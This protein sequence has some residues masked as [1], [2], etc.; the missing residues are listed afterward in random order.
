[1]KRYTCPMHSQ[2]IKDE[3]GNC[4]LCGM[5]LVAMGGT[6]QSHAHHHTNNGHN[7][8]EG[9]HTSEFLQRFWVSMVLTIPILL[10]SE[11]IQQ[12]FGFKISFA[13]DKYVL[14]ALGTFLYVYGGS[15]FLKGMIGEI[16]A[17]AIGMMT[18]VAL[19]ISVAYL[20]SAAV[21]FGLAGMDFFW[22][23]ATLIDIM[24]LG[25][26]LEMR[27]QTA[28]SKALQS[29]VALLPSTVRIEKGDE[30]VEV[31]LDHLHSD[32]IFIIRPGEKIPADGAVVAG[33]SY[34]NESFLTGESVPIKKEDGNKVIAGSI[35][36]DGMLKVRATG[37]G[38]DSYLNKVIN[39]VQEAQ[40]TKSKTQNLADTV[41]KWLTYIAILAGSM[42]FLYWY[43]SGVSLSYALE[44]MVT[45]MV[46]ACPHALGVAIPLVV[47]IS[48]TLSATNGLLIRNRTAFEIARNIDIIV[49]DKTG[50]LTKGSHVIHHIIPLNTAYDEQ[51]IIQYAAAAQQHSEHHIAKGILNYL[52]EKKWELWSSS[53]FEY[54]Q[55]MGVKSQVNDKLIVAAGPNYFKTNNIDIPDIPIQI[56][57]SVE[58]VN[59]L[60]ID[61]TPVGIITFADTIREGAKETIDS[62]KDMGIQ[63]HLLTGDNEHIAKY[64]CE[65]LNMD[66]YMSSILPHQKQEKIKDFQAQGSIVAMTGDGVNDAPALAQANVGIAVG[67][68]TD[69]AAETADIILVHSDPRDVVKII[70]F[71]KRSYKKM[72]QN[73]AWAVGYNIIAIPLAAGVLAPHFILSPAIGAILMSLSTII[74]AFNASLLKINKK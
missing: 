45:V 28:A 20:Y 3:P 12:W 13:G 37:V 58:T 22:E 10:L 66:G 50:T 72:I 61:G 47:S 42:T 63:T 24:L 4:P 67:S 32:D 55:G 6:T 15:P 59:F 60:L 41:A 68:G 25:H 36:G 51:Q 73:I 39:L 53:D 1:M 31:S 19:A 8:H 70:D 16:K 23:L 48:T 17:K 2:I 62:L 74:V 30:I 33:H 69:V 26:W 7:K 9:H 71:A 40:E 27:S 46:T 21:I 54:M 52:T 34:V 65:S 49:F 35:N 57:Q 29:L 38:K 18:L 56:N 43:S 5:S 64:V 14:F 11:M 44:R